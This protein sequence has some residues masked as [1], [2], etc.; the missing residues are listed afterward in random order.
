MEKILFVFAKQWIAG[1][2][3][4]DALK[5]SKLSY[6]NGR[7]AIVN[8]LGEYHKSKTQINKTVKEYQKIVS[9]FRKWKVRGAISVKPTQI[10]LSISKKECIRNFQILIKKA[11][12]SHIFLWIDMESS[13]HTDETIEIYYHLFARYERLGIAIQAN[14]KRTKNDL[15]DL[16]EHGAKIRLVK[17]AYKEN[18]RIAF[19]SKEKVDGNYARLMKILF[20]NGNEFGIAT[21]DSKM[22]DLAISLSKKYKRKFEFQMLKGIRDELKP[23]LIKK[24]F[25]VSDYIPYGTN[26][27][28]YSIRRVKERKRNILLL[29]S[30]FFQAHRV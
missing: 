30:S 25:V 5:S 26:W 1:D 11:A 3:I 6:K 2:S 18:S 14:L 12:S 9:S 13:D 24:H 7:H 8:K 16:L 15:I 19:Q 20:K 23:I 22:I 4:D 28:P 27:L 17:G 10:G 29:G 21:H